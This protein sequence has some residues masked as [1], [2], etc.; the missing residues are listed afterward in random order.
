[1][2]RAQLKELKEIDEEKKKLSLFFDREFPQRDRECRVFLTKKINILNRISLLEEREKEIIEA[3]KKRSD[4]FNES[5]RRSWIAGIKKPCSR[6][7]YRDKRRY[8]DLACSLGPNG[9]YYW[10]PIG[11]IG[12]PFNISYLNSRNRG[13]YERDLKEQFDMY[14]SPYEP[15]R[16]IQT[17]PQLART[18]QVFQG[19]SPSF[20]RRIMDEMSEGYGGIETDRET[21]EDSDWQERRKSLSYIPEE[22]IGGGKKKR[23]KKISS[24]K[25]RKKSK[26]R[27]KRKVQR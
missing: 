8:K 2:Y 4:D 23:S 27:S 14:E 12:D 20:R 11:N 7:E 1:M 3:Q 9:G 26:K 15:S 17:N 5:R 16:M 25:K 6:E 22:F 10:L 13:I 24:R 18:L 21:V 19:S